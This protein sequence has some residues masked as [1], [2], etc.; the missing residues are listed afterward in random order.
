MTD[1]LKDPKRPISP[2]P[3]SESDPGDGPVRKG[4]PVAG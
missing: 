1:N 3:P 4:P 2:A